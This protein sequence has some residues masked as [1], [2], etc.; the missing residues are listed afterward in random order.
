MLRTVETTGSGEAMDGFTVTR[1]DFYQVYVSLACAA[2]AAGR[3]VT[4]EQL[5]LGTEIVMQG[6]AASGYADCDVT[7]AG[8]HT[9]GALFDDADNGNT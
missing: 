7:E 9:G 3:S 4:C 8:R 1:S 2:L 6:A 5:K